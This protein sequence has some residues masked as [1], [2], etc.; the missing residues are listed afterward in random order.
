MH[1]IT[2]HTWT[3]VSLRHLVNTSFMASFQAQTEPYSGLTLWACIL[4]PR[5]ASILLFIATVQVSHSVPSTIWV[6]SHLCTSKH[7]S[8]ATRHKA[9]MYIH[10]TST[11]IHFFFL[12]IFHF[13]GQAGCPPLAPSA[14]PTTCLKML[15]GV[16]KKTF[17]KHLISSCPLSVFLPSS[18]F[19]RFRM[20]M[21]IN[22]NYFIACFRF[23]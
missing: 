20:T 9:H 8:N 14:T 13:P 23:F 4:L 11:T 17:L 21:K 3:A 1:N 12:H 2:I 19:F 5:P 22:Q 10:H 15:S 6:A 18:P 7:H 16:R